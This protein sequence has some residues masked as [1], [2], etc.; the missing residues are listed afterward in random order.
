MSSGTRRTTLTQK[1]ELTVR[2]VFDLVH[3]FDSADLHEQRVGRDSVGARPFV[4]DDVTLA[5]V[6][7]TYRA[8]AARGA[9]AGVIEFRMRDSI[10]RT[11]S[12]AR[13]SATSMHVGR[14]QT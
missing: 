3:E 14:A 4:D 5:P 2:G 9:G 12:S 6:E 7:P 11:G 1:G 10:G 13:G 8:T